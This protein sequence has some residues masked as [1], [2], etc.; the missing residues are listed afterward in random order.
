MVL[1]PPPPMELVPPET[2]DV[3]PPEDPPPGVLPSDPSQAVRRKR[4]ANER[5]KAE[6]EH[7]SGGVRR[8]GRGRIGR[9]YRR[10]R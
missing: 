3:V 6:D 5:E 7:G 2:P 10:R 1:V 8:R 9:D 4:A